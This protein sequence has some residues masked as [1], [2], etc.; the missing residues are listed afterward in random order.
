MNI[1]SNFF[2]GW[3]RGFCING[4]KWKNPTKL[5]GKPPLCNL[6][7]IDVSATKQPGFARQLSKDLQVT[8]SPW[9]K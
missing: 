7:V 1:S 2:M 3:S 8:D 4:K 6:L 5:P 9:E